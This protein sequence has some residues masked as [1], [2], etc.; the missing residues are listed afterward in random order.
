MATV[1][2]SK[3]T[4]NMQLAAFYYILIATYFMAGSPAS[5]ASDTPEPLQHSILHQQQQ[6]KQKQQPNI[7]SSHP[8]ERMRDP[9]KDFLYDPV[10]HSP[11]DENIL[12]SNNAQ[13]LSHLEFR[14][15]VLRFGELAVGDVNSEV[16]TVFNRH[17]NRSVYL[18]SIS[19]SAVEFYSSFFED[20]VCSSR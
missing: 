8:R 10:L 5:S 16:V 4:Y 2:S 9:T 17:P 18:G 1:V 11:S 12:V 20:K 6:H 3:C 15:S 13:D 14:P 7:Q 19:G